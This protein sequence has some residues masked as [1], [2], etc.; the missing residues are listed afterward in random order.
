MSWRPSS[1]G[2]S[3]FHESRREEFDE[4][5]LKR[6]RK[7]HVLLQ[8]Q[9]WKVLFIKWNAKVC[10]EFH[11]QWASENQL[12]LLHWI[13]SSVFMAENTQ[14]IT[15]LLRCLVSISNKET[16]VSNSWTISLIIY[17]KNQIYLKCIIKLYELV[18]HRVWLVMIHI[19]RKSQE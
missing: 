14:G 12:L 16:Y 4:S 15:F 3:S 5:I 11:H 19:W 7:R 13:L 1:Y 9:S 18:S 17:L 8:W 2:K 6:Q 10:K